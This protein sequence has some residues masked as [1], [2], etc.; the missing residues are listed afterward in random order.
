MNYLPHEWEK[1]LIETGEKG[2]ESGLAEGKLRNGKERKGGK[3]VFVLV[4]LAKDLGS[5]P[6][7]HSVSSSARRSNIV[8]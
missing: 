8:F 7:T 4:A 1:T 2:W 6:N 5:V 3:R